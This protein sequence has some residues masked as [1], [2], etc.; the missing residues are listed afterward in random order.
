MNNIISKLFVSL[1]LLGC[2]TQKNLN[3]LEKGL[4][5][6]RIAV[7][8]KAEAKIAR[9][10]IELPTFSE[11]GEVRD[12]MESGAYVSVKNAQ[13][14]STLMVMAASENEILEN[15]ESVINLKH[16]SNRKLDPISFSD[17]RVIRVY[18]FDTLAESLIR[19]EKIKL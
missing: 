6:N 19:E 4:K 13:G 5:S 9:Q 7:Q 11:F 1:S 17:I 3:N 18:A 10:K 16:F 8:A 15:R 2:V 14:M 12:M